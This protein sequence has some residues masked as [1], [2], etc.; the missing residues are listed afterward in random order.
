MNK[1]QK[2][3]THTALKDWGIK[4]SS[5]L[6]CWYLK[7]PHNFLDLNS[8]GL[9]GCV[10]FQERHPNGKR[11]KH[12][13]VK[14]TI[15]EL[16]RCGRWQGSQKEHRSGSKSRYIEF[17]SWLYYRG[18]LK[19]ILQPHSQDVHILIPGTMDMLPHMVQETLKVCLY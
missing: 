9:K 7:I 10:L 3:D 6:C 5:F 19:N 2:S 11:S 4:N 13:Q 17:K 15:K 18:E 8:S 16:F 1:L 14:Y 12:R